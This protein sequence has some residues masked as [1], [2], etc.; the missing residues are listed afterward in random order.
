MCISETNFLFF[1]G[2]KDEKICSKKYNIVFIRIPMRLGRA[3]WPSRVVPRERNKQSD[4]DK[5]R[6]PMRLSLVEMFTFH[7]YKP[8]DKGP[9]QHRMHG[10]GVERRVNFSDNSSSI[11]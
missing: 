3:D 5:S 11:F 1:R 7:I 8:S 9:N 4:S 10:A 2:R 6:F